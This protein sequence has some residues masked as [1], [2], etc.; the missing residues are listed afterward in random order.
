MSRKYGSNNSAKPKYAG[1]KLK[2]RLVKALAALQ[3]SKNNSSQKKKQCI[4]STAWQKISWENNSRNPSN[5]SQNYISRIGASKQ[6]SITLN[7]SLLKCF[8]LIYAQDMDVLS[9]KGLPPSSKAIIHFIM[10]CQMQHRQPLSGH[11]FNSFLSLGL[12]VILYFVS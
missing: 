11:Q 12:Q 4:C 10:L 8:S 2:N 9:Q 5:F 7:T 6:R 1:L 3:P